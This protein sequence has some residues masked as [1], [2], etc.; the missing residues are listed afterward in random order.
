MH[1]WADGPC[2][3]LGSVS[4]G[5]PQRECRANSRIMPS[6]GKGSWV[7][8]LSAV[9]SYWWRDFPK[10]HYLPGLSPLCLSGLQWSDRTQ[11]RRSRVQIGRSYSGPWAEHQECVLQKVSWCAALLGK[12]SIALTEISKIQSGESLLFTPP[13]MIIPS[14]SLIK[15]DRNTVPLAA[16]SA[17]LPSVLVVFVTNFR[18]VSQVMR[19]FFFN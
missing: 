9:A 13:V 19:F 5:N 10:R 18:N 12:L 6:K 16:G 7:I 15:R 3:Q 17:A 8:H 2:D 1:Y 14:I 11:R 4:L